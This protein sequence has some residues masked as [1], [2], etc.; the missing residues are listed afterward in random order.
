MTKGRPADPTRAT[1]KTGN[2]PLP[3]EAKKSVAVVP[4]EAR[5]ML[6]EPPADL[7]EGAA[8][9]FRKV[10]AELDTRGLKETDVEAVAMLSHS[11]W[12]HSE[13]RRIIAE[14]GMMVPLPNGGYGLNPMV[15][16]AR[17]EAATYMK[18]AA[19]FGLTPA[20]R[21]RLGLMTLA[22]QSLAQT[23]ANELDRA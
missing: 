13:A 12:V 7:P 22:G 6:P 20:A 21:L 19:E 18:I 8:V 10:I 16:V 14:T 1:R 2:R 9:V 4:L 23:L 3:G 17:D 5:V 11:A 15:K